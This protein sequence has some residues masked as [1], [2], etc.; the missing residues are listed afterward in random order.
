ME[1]FSEV[2]SLFL[3]VDNFIAIAIGVIV[4]VVVGA[5]PGLTATMAVALALPF[6]FSMETVPAILLLVGIYNIGMYVGSFTAI[7]IRTAGSL[8]S[9]CTLLDGYA[10]AQPSTATKDL[11]TALE[12]FAGAAMISS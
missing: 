1:N 4:G 5:I 9:A 11:Q 2:M 12:S 8:A 6:T 3:S 7:L 10:M